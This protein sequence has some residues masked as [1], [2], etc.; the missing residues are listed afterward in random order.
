MA[1]LGFVRVSESY[2][3][4]L[5]L[6]RPRIQNIVR[7]KNRDETFWIN[8]ND[9]DQENI[10]P[11]AVMKNKVPVRYE[12][13]FILVHLGKMCSWLTADRSLLGFYQEQEKPKYLLLARLFYAFPGRKCHCER[14]SKCLT[15]YNK[16]A[17]KKTEIPMTTIYFLG[18]LHT[19]WNTI[20]AINTIF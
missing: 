5:P 9:R 10:T 20:T 11:P 13:H 18:S 1:F 17:N 4:Y 12:I 7:V 8:L 3:V 2:I 14:F 6:K 19:L 15:D 16:Q